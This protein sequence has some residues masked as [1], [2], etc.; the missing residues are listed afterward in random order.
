MYNVH[1]VGQVAALNLLR[2]GYELRRR[3]KLA[4]ER[5]QLEVPSSEVIGEV[6]PKHRLFQFF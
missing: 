2:T 5:E 6:N 1:A 3:H 4:C